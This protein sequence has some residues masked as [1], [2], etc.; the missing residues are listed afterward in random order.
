MQRQQQGHA[1]L[2]LPLGI[3]LALL[4]FMLPFICYATLAYRAAFF[5]FAVKDACNHACRASSFTKAKA[6]SA[7]IF[8]H[9]VASFT[10]IEN[11]TI[12]VFAVEQPLPPANQPQAPV[13]PPTQVS[14]SPLSQVQTDTDAYYIQINGYAT[15]QPL[16]TAGGWMGLNIPGMT[17]PY[18]LPIICKGYVE[19]PQG[20]L[21]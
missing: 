10:G 6:I 4:F 11:A 19:N 9:D 12:Q 7:E 8:A 21:Q 13:P 16:I 17:G 3:W 14:A 20:L 1:I 2:E 5:Y 15:V 18:S